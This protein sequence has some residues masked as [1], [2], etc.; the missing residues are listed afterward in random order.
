MKNIIN[1][2][3]KLEHQIKPA[4][5]AYGVMIENGR[6]FW[7]TEKPKTINKQDIVFTF[8]TPSEMK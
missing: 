2:I 1:R 4:R 3:E 8:L 7:L 6:E 5:K